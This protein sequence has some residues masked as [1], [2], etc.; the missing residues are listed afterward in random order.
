MRKSDKY[1][2]GIKIYEKSSGRFGVSKNFLGKTL[3]YKENHSIRGSRK[4]LKLFK[5][6]IYIKKI[7]W[8]LITYQYFSLFSRKVSIKN[9]FFKFIQKNLKNYDDI[10]YLYSNGG[11]A[12]MFFAY[13][14]KNFIKKNN[15]KRP[16]FIATQPFQLDLLRLY[17]PDAKGICI[18]DFFFLHEYKNMIPIK[19][20]RIFLVYSH[21]HFEPLEKEM[22]S[23]NFENITC[24]DHILNTLELTRKDCTKPEFKI[25]SHYENTLKKKIDAINLNIDNFVIIAPETKTSKPLSK[26]L[27]EKLIN[28]F[29]KRGVD[30][31]L[32]IK[33]EEFVFENCKQTKLSYPEAFLLAKKAKSIICVKSGFV[34]VLL[35]VNCPTIAVYTEF[36]N[37][38]RYKITPEQVISVFS[39]HKLPFVNHDLI[40]ELNYDNFQNDDKLFET[41]MLNYDKMRI[42]R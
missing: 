17:F 16:F 10:Y 22:Q 19:N 14:A 9:L 34:E 41:I 29:R 4:S 6:F 1:F 42:N 8:G 12:S 2:C 39:M 20:H 5:F 11:E 27:W 31:F 15:S 28:E 30:I 18:K 35:P 21:G 32:N 25:P 33:D 24:F 37:K 7:T 40:C 38:K 23:Q 26:T 13:C 36:R 3:C